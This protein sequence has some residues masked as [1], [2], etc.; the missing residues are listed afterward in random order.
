MDYRYMR[1]VDRA[2]NDTAASH[3]FFWIS[4]I[5]SGGVIRALAYWQGMPIEN[6]EIFWRVLL[7]HVSLAF[8]SPRPV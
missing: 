4:D 8:S 1:P 5:Y 6:S 2:C 3:G 7:L